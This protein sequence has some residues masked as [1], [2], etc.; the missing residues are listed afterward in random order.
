MD[1][2]VDFTPTERIWHTIRMIPAGQVAAYGQIADLAGLP[3]RARMVGRSLKAVPSHEVVPWFR[4]LRSNGQIA[5]PVG[6]EHANEQ[7]ARLQEEGVLVVNHRVD[8]KRYQWQP[9]LPTLLYQLD[10]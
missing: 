3:G 7:I 2:N 4:V 6:S 1:R 5:F 9:D 10:F 8:M